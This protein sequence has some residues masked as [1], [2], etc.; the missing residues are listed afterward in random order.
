MEF[1][2]CNTAAKK[3]CLSRGQ[4]C[5]VNFIYAGSKTFW[6]IFKNRFPKR[7]KMFI[8]TLILLMAYVSQGKMDDECGKNYYSIKLKYCKQLNLCR[9]VA[10]MCN[11]PNDGR[12]EC[13][14]NICVPNGVKVFNCLKWIKRAFMKMCILNFTRCDARNKCVREGECVSP[15][16]ESEKE[17]TTGT[18]RC[19]DRKREYCPAESCPDFKYKCGYQ[20][21]IFPC[22]K[23]FQFIDNGATQEHQ[24]EN[25]PYFIL[26]YIFIPILTIIYSFVLCLM[27]HKRC[28]LSTNRTNENTVLGPLPELPSLTIRTESSAICNTNEKYRLRAIPLSS[29]PSY[30]EAINSMRQG[31]V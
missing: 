19:I 24:N 26:F 21:S 23:R 8:N 3:I 1:Y 6:L 15:C 9:T 20:C 30:S 2:Q 18:R 14:D 7:L 10:S 22:E 25:D 29:P 28:R 11:C 27:C 17:C 12:I 4:Y 5:R 31:S 16:S 13:P